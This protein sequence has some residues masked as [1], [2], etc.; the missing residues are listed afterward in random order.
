MSEKTMLRVPDARSQTA[1]Y[2]RYFNEEGVTADTVLTAISLTYQRTDVFIRDALD[3]FAEKKLFESACKA[4]CGYCCHTHVSVLPP[5]AFHVADY[6]ESAFNA[7]ERDALKAEVRKRDADYRGADG[8]KRYAERAACPFLDGESWNCRLHAG[9][10]TVCR[11]MHSGSLP[12]CITAYENRDPDVATPTMRAFFD[13][14]NAT[15][16]G[17]TAVLGQRG[18]VMRPVEMNA[19]LVSIWDGDDVMADWLKGRDVFAGL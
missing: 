15:Y 3:T 4:G 19:A 17:L 18:I 8:A 5:E 7:A 12:A 11:A 13:N 1:L 6:I 16:A 2:E 14:R 9:R 10:P